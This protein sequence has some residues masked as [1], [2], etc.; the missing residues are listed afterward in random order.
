MGKGKIQNGVTI[1]K[2][3]VN[4]SYFKVSGYKIN[5]IKSVAFLYSKNKS[6]VK[7]VRGM[8][9]YTIVTNN[10]KYRGVSLKASERPV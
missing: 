4:Y 6:T 8:T 10:I 5:S 2:S 3:Q 9:P 7:E 1:L